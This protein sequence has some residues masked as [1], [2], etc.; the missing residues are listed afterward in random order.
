MNKKLL[1][2][3]ATS[4]TCKMVQKAEDMG[5][6]TF[7]VD[8]YKNSQ[9][10]VF[11][12][13]SIDM[14]CFDIDG[15]CEVIE[16]EKIDGILPGCADILVEV[17][18]KICRRMNLHCYVNSEIVKVFNNKK[19]L[20]KALLKYGLDVIKEYSYEEVINNSF[21][22]YP[23]FVKP[24]DNNSSKGMSVAN[25]LEEFKKAYEYALS[26]SKS[27]TVLIEEY[28]Q[29]DDF[30]IG[31]FLQDGNV[32][33]AFSGDR[34]VINQ[35]NY[36]SITSAIVYPSKYIKLYFDTVHN[37]MLN[38]LKDLD[39]KN[40]I[41]AIQAFVDKDKILFY[42]PALRITGGQE[43]VLCDYFYHVN[44]LEALINY[45]IYGKISE[46]VLYEKVDCSFNNHYACNLTFSVRK[47]KINKINGLDYAR[48][49]K[50]V[51]NVTQEH[52]EG[53]IIDRIGTA[54]QNIS[55][56]HLVANS[57]EELRDVVNDLQNKINVIDENGGNAII[58]GFDANKWF[59]GNEE[60]A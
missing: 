57:K 31:Y 56:M 20:K 48:K 50:N 32:K 2:L 23:V 12:S 6:D 13:H 24:V 58:Q 37:K 19:G 14:D 55:R 26:F 17:Y 16:K 45:A 5:I 46:D 53:D 18:E 10:K 3:G 21:D 36:G 59:K 15:I 54:Q 29:C 33:V 38:L 41:L 40:G 7:V 35:E 39:F 51:I 47:C 60:Q 27:N 1:I 34:F 11:A 52:K 43:Y 25:N 8:P 22:N 30:F 44:E 28:K 9:A 42:D 4:E 49:H